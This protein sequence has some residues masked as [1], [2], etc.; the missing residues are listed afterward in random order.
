[1]ATLVTALLKHAADIT[2]S[3]PGPGL[4]QCWHLQSSLSFL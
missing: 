3:W 1:M 4:R 2:V